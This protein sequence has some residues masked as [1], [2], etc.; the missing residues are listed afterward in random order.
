M[1]DD[2][3]E[4][5][6]RTSHIGEVKIAGDVV[7][8]IAG[9]ATTEVDGIAAMQGNLTNDIVKRLGARN[10]SKGVKVQINDN[11]VNVDLSVIVKYGHN[12]PKTIQK[13]QE[14]VKSS[15]EMMTG[16]KVLEVNIRIVGVASEKVTR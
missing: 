9:L 3:K 10:S 5:K 15:I 13:V 2:N 11:Y 8:T 12:I 4:N 16:F 14:N 6:E 1:M 7:A